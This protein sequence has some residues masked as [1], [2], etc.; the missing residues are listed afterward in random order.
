M[1][2]FETRVIKSNAFGKNEPKQDLYITRMHS[3]LFKNDEKNI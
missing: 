1:N 2:E 3:L